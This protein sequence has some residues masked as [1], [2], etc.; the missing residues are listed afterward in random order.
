MHLLCLPAEVTHGSNCMLGNDR[1]AGL[2][3]VLFISNAC[4]N[5]LQQPKPSILS[6]IAT[7]VQAEDCT[8]YC[9]ILT[10]YF[11]KVISCN[12]RFNCQQKSLVY[13]RAQH[14]KIEHCTCTVLTL[15]GIKN[16]SNCQAIFL[17]LLCC[18]R[19]LSRDSCYVEIHVDACKSVMSAL[20]LKLPTKCRN[21]FSR[22]IKQKETLA[23]KRTY[24]PCQSTFAI[25]RATCKAIKTAADLFVRISDYKG[26]L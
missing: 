14:L 2:F 13:A 9:S 19:F 1:I 5:L 23:Y 16:E 25:Q 11:P 15:V 6:F 10:I 8:E 18:A 4:H 22:L 3:S 24:T 7:F 12:N 17:F 20:Q 26:G 21:M